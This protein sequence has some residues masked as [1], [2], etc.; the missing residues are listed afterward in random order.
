MCRNRKSLLLIA[1][2]WLLVTVISFSE[3]ALAQE[4]PT[5]PITLVIRSGAG[6]TADVMARL[7][8]KAA[9]KE[10]G[11]PIVC[12]NRAGAGG[13]VGVSYVLKSKP[14]GYTIGVTSVSNFVNS[15]HMEKIPYDSLTDVTTI[16][17][18]IKV[19]HSLCV[20]ALEDFRR[21]DRICTK[22]SGEIYLW[23][24]RRYRGGSTHRHGADRHER[25]RP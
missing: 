22:K 13:V 1:F 7:I 24:G 19:P 20:R 8:A 21:G 9:E 12:E 14:D 15:P 25:R 6:G 16:L 17:M 10:L 4:F 11:Q 5:K 2:L 23:A 18:Y 3:N